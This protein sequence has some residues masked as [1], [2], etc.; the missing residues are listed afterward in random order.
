[1]SATNTVLLLDSNVWSHLVL[2]QAEKQTSVRRAI[3]V[4]VQK[5]PGAVLATSQICVAECLVGARRLVDVAQ[6]EAA[7]TALN[8]QFA[9]PQ[10]ILV[11]VT[12][13][14]LDRAASLRAQG[15]RRVAARA[16]HNN[17]GNGAK[18]KLPDAIVAASC[19]EFS[20]RAVLVT[21]N[22]ADFV[23]QEDGVEKTVG[24]LIVERVG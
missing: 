4:L 14:V 10:L 16:G 15:I 13:Q 22:H 1:M 5:Y 6:R 18:L 21:E 19:L 23:Y 20:P 2:G 11:E 24:G 17:A 12:A 9:Q 7:E 8:Q 3:G